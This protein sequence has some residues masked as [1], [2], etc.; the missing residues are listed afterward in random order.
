MED[1]W[2]SALG[3]AFSGVLE[4]QAFLFADP[5]EPGDFAVLGG[6]FMAVTVGFSG[7]IGGRLTMA[8]S[9]SLMPEI[10][11]NFLGMD[12]GDPFVAARSGDACKEVLNVACGHLLTAMRGEEPVFDLTIPELS[13]VGASTVAAWARQP[14]TL[15]FNVEGRPLLLRADIVP[16]AGEAGRGAGRE[17]P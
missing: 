15:L 9:K 7:E 12:A 6:D 17:R 10:A 13:A 11:S 3:R 8:L 4:R 5:A 16:E 1:D 2:A 14:G